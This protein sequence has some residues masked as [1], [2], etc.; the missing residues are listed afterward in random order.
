M[1]E[2]LSADKFGYHKSAGL[3]V[4]QQ[5]I[6]EYSAHRGDVK[7]DDVFLSSGGSMAFEMCVKALANPGDNILVPCPAWNYCT[8][9]NGNDIEPLYY[10][11]LPNEDWRVDLKHLESL[12]NC[13]TKAILVNNPGNPCGNVFSRENL[14]EIIEIAERHKLPIIADEIYE[15]ITLSGVEFHSI[16]SLSENVPVLTCSGTAKR[17]LM[18]GSRIGWVILN[19]RGNKLANVRE[20][21]KNIAGRNFMPNSTFQL[22]LPKTLLETPDEFFMDVNQKLTVSAF[23]RQ[24]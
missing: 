15:F 18:P 6:A 13:K 8:W 7:A 21:L 2:A 19:D 20:A 23:L 17:H 10:N 3:E 12:I 1:K 4:A 24:I 16:A 22:A 14:R 11:L 5:A 9:L